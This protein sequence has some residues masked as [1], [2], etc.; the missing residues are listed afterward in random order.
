MYRFV[1]IGK[2]T[3][4]EKKERERVRTLFLTFLR[5]YIEWRF[6]NNNL[7]SQIVRTEVEHCR[8]RN[9]KSRTFESIQSRN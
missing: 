6:G 8:S 4:G 2:R 3:L 5:R 9:E 1:L 7:I